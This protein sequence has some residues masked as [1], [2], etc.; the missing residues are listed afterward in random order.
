MKRHVL[1]LFIAG[2]VGACQSEPA[3]EPAL[4]EP[5][6]EN[7]TRAEPG[8]YELTTSE[9]AVNTLILAEDG[10]YTSMAE[11]REPLSGTWAVVGGR[12]CFTPIGVEAMPTC[13]T[14]GP[15]G[16]DGSWTATPEE[17]EPITIRKIG[18]APEQ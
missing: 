12:A 7:T 13:Y 14:D 18:E 8:T 17:G 9:G 5:V 6:V 15:L 10:M 11:G 2:A 3:E 1:T 16:E 4:A